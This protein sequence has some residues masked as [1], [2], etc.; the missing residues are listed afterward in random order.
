VS[1]GAA[2]AACLLASVLA[3]GP[4]EAA[5]IWL[6]PGSAGV[7][8]FGLSLSDRGARP[9]PLGSLQIHTC[10]SV[11]SARSTSWIPPR[12]EAVWYIDWWPRDAD[13]PAP[14]V[15]TVVYGDVPD[16]MQEDHPASPLG[17]SGACYVVQAAGGGGGGARTLRTGFR[18]TESGA[19]RELTPAQI[20]S[21]VRPAARA[22]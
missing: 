14:R 19:T 16:G 4:G 22:P 21:I 8:V 7:P 11:T 17:G 12:E 20:D 6:Q 5:R 10:R 13:H 2:R 1:A 18:I 9:F 3:C 15:E